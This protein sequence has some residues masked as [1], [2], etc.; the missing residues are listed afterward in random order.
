MSFYISACY[1]TRM[2]GVIYAHI[3]IHSM[4]SFSFIFI[5]RLRSYRTMRNLPF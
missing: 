3:S 2:K 5:I 4:Y 1:V